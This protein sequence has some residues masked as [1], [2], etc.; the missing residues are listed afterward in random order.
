[1]KHGQ[2]LKHLDQRGLI[3]TNVNG[4]LNVAPRSALSDIDIKHLGDHK[5]EIL[6]DLALRD[7]TV[8]DARQTIAG[9]KD[10]L[11]LER[12]LARSHQC[13]ELG[14]LSTPQ[15]E[16]IA[17]LCAEQSRSIPPAGAV[18]APAERMAAKVV[19][20]AI[21]FDGDVVQASH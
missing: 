17:S 14:H 21:A 5:A 20:T 10:W 2:Y 15:V 16:E 13:W 19:Q 6:A 9:A 12:A 8:A 7:E 3:L 4:A 11:P 18:A 1:M